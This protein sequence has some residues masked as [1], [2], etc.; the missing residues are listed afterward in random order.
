MPVITFY[1]LPLTHMHIHTHTYTHIHPKVKTLHLQ[2]LQ[3]R[4]K[5]IIMQRGTSCMQFNLNKVKMPSFAYINAQDHTFK[6]QFP[7]HIMAIHSLN[8]YG[9]YPKSNQQSGKMP[10]TYIAICLLLLHHKKL[11][12]NKYHNDLNFVFSHVHEFLHSL[13]DSRISLI[14]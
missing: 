12:F 1:S 4:K 7:S 9:V 2:C 8:I 10:V 3:L 13:I 14:F 11:C 5:I 6:G